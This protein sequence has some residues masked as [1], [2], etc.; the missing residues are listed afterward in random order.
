MNLSAG[1]KNIKE[2]TD[3]S[4]RMKSMA[5]HSQKSV[6]AIFLR[7][8]VLKTSGDRRSGRAVGEGLSKYAEAE[9][10]KSRDCEIF[11]KIFF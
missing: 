10:K 8:I 5:E 6:S 1:W 9:M 7:T 4:F 11:Q 2:R 3:P